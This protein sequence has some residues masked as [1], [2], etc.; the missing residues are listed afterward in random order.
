MPGMVPPQFGILLPFEDGA[1]VAATI[2]GRVSRLPSK[3]RVLA[4]SDVMLAQ[5]ELRQGDLMLR[6]FIGNRL[7]TA[8]VTRRPGFLG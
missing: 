6:S 8:T 3:C 5:G 1:A 2:T 7:H 4:T